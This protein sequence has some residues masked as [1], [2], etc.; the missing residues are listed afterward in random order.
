MSALNLDFRPLSPASPLSGT[1]TRAGSMAEDLQKIQLGLLNEAFQKA[2][3]KVRTKKLES[4]SRVETP[5]DWSFS[6]TNTP[7]VVRH[8]VVR[9]KS[10][11]SLANSQKDKDE[12]KRH[13]SFSA[14]DSPASVSRLSFISKAGDKTPQHVASGRTTPVTPGEKTPRQTASGRNTPLAPDPRLQSLTAASREGSFALPSIKP[15]N[16]HSRRTSIADGELDVSLLADALAEDTP[17]ST[18]SSGSKTPDVSVTEMS[19]GPSYLRL[20]QCLEKIN[21]A[22]KSAF[23]QVN[24][25][26]S[27]ELAYAL[28]LLALKQ[29]EKEDNLRFALGLNPLPTPKLE[30]CQDLR[31]RRDSL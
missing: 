4:A 21:R 18:T 28:S 26:E 19:A 22:I 11:D 6:A 17:K 13:F 12:K 15:L 24:P 3:L 30:D 29:K 16:V 1:H 9:P 23:E 5:S 7:K 2:L 31:K 27:G 14:T 8:L 20:D 10:K 25:D